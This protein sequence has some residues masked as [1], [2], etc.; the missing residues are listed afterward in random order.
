MTYEPFPAVRRTVVRHDRGV[1]LILIAILL[2]TNVGMGYLTWHL[3]G[4]EQVY[5][6][7][8]IY[9]SRNLVIQWGGVE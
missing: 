8:D 5:S 6:V 2:L 3:L 7:P 1:L 9:S 4:H